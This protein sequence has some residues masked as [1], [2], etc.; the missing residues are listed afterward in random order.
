M[1]E[2]WMRAVAAESESNAREGYG[3]ALA[4]SRGV[5]AS[6]GCDA[7]SVWL[8]GE[9]TAGPCETPIE[10]PLLDSSRLARL[11]RWYDELA[12]F[13]SDG[14]DGVRADSFVERLVFA[15]RGHREATPAEKAEIRRFASTLL[16]VD[17]QPSAAPPPANPD[18]GSG[19][20]ETG[21]PLVRLVQ[22]PVARP[23]PAPAAPP[24]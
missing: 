8:S 14:T 4:W 2:A 6:I 9:V 3:L 23:T 11:Y 19:P 1:F 16:R 5:A 18:D 17:A 24:P 20:S 10:R 21:A 15:S 22:T 13:Q 7:V 12:P